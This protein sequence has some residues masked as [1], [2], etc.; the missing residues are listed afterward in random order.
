[1]NIISGFN[2]ISTVF[3]V[4]ADLG[5]DFNNP[6]QFSI[7]FDTTSSSGAVSCVDIPTIDDTALE[8]D[9]NFSISLN[10]SNLLGNV[11]LSTESVAAVIQ[12]NDSELVGTIYTIAC[13]RG[14]DPDSI[15]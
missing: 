14:L 11:Q 13:V 1:M 5:I 8:G 6:T 9:H 10:S 12:D 15:L 7:T 2:N 4:F 3:G